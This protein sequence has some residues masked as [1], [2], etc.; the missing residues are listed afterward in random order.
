MDAPIAL[1][2]VATATLTLVTTGASSDLT[3]NSA[4]TTAAGAITLTAGRNLVFGGEARLGSTSGD[5]TLTATAGTLTLPGHVVVNA[6]AG[7]LT[8]T[9][10]LNLTLGKLTSSASG[11]LTITSVA[12]AIMDGGEGNRDIIAPNASLVLRAATGIGSAG[13]DI[14]IQVASLDVIN[15]ASGAVALAEADALTITRL[16]QGGAGIVSVATLDGALILSTSGLSAT[17]GAVT[18]RAGGASGGGFRLGANLITT[19]GDVTLFADSGDLILAAGI[20]TPGAISL[21]ALQGSILNDAAA[22]NWLTGS[23]NGFS[24]HLDWAIG[25]A[26]FAINPATGLLTVAGATAAEQAA[27][28]ANGTVLRAAG[29]AYLQAGGVITLRARDQIGAPTAGLQY[30]PLSLLIRGAKAT[31]S[32]SSRQPVYIFTAADIVVE[33]ESVGGS[34]TKAGT[35][36][37]VSL[38]GGQIIASP[39]DAGGEDLS[40]VADDL[41]IGAPI[42]SAGADL[43]MRPRG[44]DVAIYLGDFGTPITGFHID[45][46]E[47]AYIQNGFREIQI[48][49]PEGSYTIYVG[50]SATTTGQI[51]VYD[52]LRLTNPAAGGHIYI[53]DDLIGRDDAYLIIRGSGATTT[54]AADISFPSGID[55]GDSIIVS[56]SR[57]LSAPSGSLIIGA[58]HNPAYTLN[59]DGNAATTD[60]L[61]IS[62]ADDVTFLNVI[63]NTDPLRG[64]TITQA[65]NVTFDLNVNL[66]GD[67]VI[68]ATGTVT[69]NGNVNL[70]GG[71]LIIRGASQVTFNGSVNVTGDMEIEGDGIDFLGGDSS[72]AGQGALLLRTSTLNLPIEVATSNVN[73]GGLDLIARDILAL[74]DG[75][76][77]ITIGQETA[78]HTTPGAGTIRIGSASD[79]VTFRDPVSLFGRSI[80]V[81]DPT[82]PTATLVAH[83]D[84]SL[85]AINNITIRN[86]MNV[87]GN[88][89]LYS[90]SGQITQNDDT[91]DGLTSEP[92]AATDLQLNA[93]TGLRLRFLAVDSLTALNRGSGNIDLVQLAAGGDLL[94]NGLTQSAASETGFIR[95][96]AQGGNITFAGPV[97]V[98]GSGEVR[99]TG[100]ASLI[101]NAA[102]TTQAAPVTLLAASNLTL[103]A[104]VASNGGAI[105]F[106]ATP[107]KTFGP[108]HHAHVGVAI[109]ATSA[110]TPVASRA[111]RIDCG[112]TSPTRPS[113]ARS[114]PARSRN[115]AVA[116]SRLIML[117]VVAVGPN[118]V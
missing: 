68:D 82:S 114:R 35:T 45:T 74:A 89:S 109:R 64:L 96:V 79:A 46:T 84:M 85:D 113:G 55:L 25:E 112:S 108:P 90:A 97:S 107:G 36:A 44:R 69:F 73:T 56:G 17:T 116:T 60:A 34:G 28:L 42:A 23:I 91:A 21:T 16:T 101:V 50:D 106:T 54:I 4:L 88:L 75:F 6:G 14:E 57:T 26:L 66:N 62:A 94:V 103:N 10:Q 43:L 102:I 93:L 115:S 92:L 78:G 72:I 104:P 2:G 5:V 63:G 111:A 11:A 29:G 40:L 12:G 83:G 31:V 95:I 1:T 30:S 32:S 33:S 8:L 13:A 76:T 38:G 22:V 51:Y 27:H 47:L 77:S 58:A 39:I 65:Q 48:G 19:G 81:V 3:V 24:S 52:P 41:T 118:R 71:R 7:H 105:T 86:A 18:L 49:S 37:I 87:T 67:L 53:D 59:G 117:T 70:N 98:A 99:A 61:T 9:A 80:E 15:S 110:R 20:T 100:S